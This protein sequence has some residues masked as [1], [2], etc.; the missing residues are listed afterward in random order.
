MTKRD[1]LT[2]NI[3]HVRRGVHQSSVGI[4]ELSARVTVVER[5]DERVWAL[6]RRAG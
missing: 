2:A 1:R 4:R 6:E 5:L 3:A